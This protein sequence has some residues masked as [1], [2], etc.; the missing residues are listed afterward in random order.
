MEERSAF[1]RRTQFTN[2]D[3]DHGD[4]R[5]IDIDHLLRYEY[6]TMTDPTATVRRFYALGKRANQVA[7]KRQAAD[8]GVWG[9]MDRLGATTSAQKSRIIEAR[10]FATLYTDGQ[11]DALCSLGRTNGRSLTRSHVV[12]LIRIADRRD[13]NILAR[14]CAS[15]SWSVRWLEMEVRRRVSGHNYGG[16]KHEPPQSVDEA[17]RVTERI[18][19]GV[20]RWVSVLKESGTSRVAWNRLP[21]PMRHDLDALAVF[22]KMI[23]ERAAENYRDPKKPRRKRPH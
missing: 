14:K 6:S 18:A 23:C 22:A 11:L 13:R 2:R 7:A 15:E 9:T 8:N 20:A 12:Q 3:A 1:S 21:R 10:R 5:S 19:A 4:P 16:R 17:V